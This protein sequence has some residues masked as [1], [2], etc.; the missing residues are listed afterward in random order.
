ME[1]TV[2][3][4]QLKQNMNKMAV[5]MEYLSQFGIEL[6]PKSHT[7]WTIFSLNYIAL[8]I[9][10]GN[11]PKSKEH[12]SFSN[13]T[14]AQYKGKNHETDFPYV[15]ILK[16]SKFLFFGWIHGIWNGFNLRYSSVLSSCSDIGS[17]T[18]CTTRELPFFF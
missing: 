17:L 18:H 15:F 3:L 1:N 16:F 8:H 4:I 12:I 2:V 5:L 7:S 11:F 13:L 6:W 9:F 10:W 14:Q